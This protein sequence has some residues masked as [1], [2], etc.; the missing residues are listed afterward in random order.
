[1]P[2]LPEVETVRVGLER[3]VVGRRIIDVEVSGERT[4]RRHPSG[5]EDFVARMAGRRVEAARRRGKYLW[6]PLDDGVNLLAHLGMSGQFL[7]LPANAPPSR[8]QRARWRFDDDGPELRFCDQRTF[9]GLALDDG[10]LTADGVPWALRHVAPDP[11]EPAY[12]RRRVS[13]AM[14]RRHTG[15]KRAILDQT[16]VSGIGNIY[17]DESLWRARLHFERP[18]ERLRPVEVE[19]LLD[20]V[21]EVLREAIS[22][23]GTSFDALYVAVNGE[24]G[25]FDRSLE[26]YGQEGRPC[27]RCGTPIVRMQFTNRSS[28]LCPHCQRRPRR[29]A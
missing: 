6:L 15:V 18:T 28:Y 8:H 20:A 19:R 4:V 13:L 22:A 16:L 26:V 24:S 1:V 7:A 5:P 12:D 23:G 29:I 2:E 17:A 3:W 14:R 11:L 25:W 9:G 21:D 10:G 27:S